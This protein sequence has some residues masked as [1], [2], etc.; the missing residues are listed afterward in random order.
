MPA[1]GCRGRLQVAKGLSPWTPD[2]MDVLFAGIIPSLEQ[3]AAT[4][5]N[6]YATSNL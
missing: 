6:S 3:A 5:G 4:L 1:R 2:K